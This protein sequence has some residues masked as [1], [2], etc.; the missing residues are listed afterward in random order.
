MNPHQASEKSIPIPKWAHKATNQ[1]APYPLPYDGRLPDQDS[2]ARSSMQN[3]HGFPSAASSSS[4]GAIGYFLEGDQM[5]GGVPNFA[6]TPHDEKRQHKILDD[7]SQKA[8]LL[9]LRMTAWEFRLKRVLKFLEDYEEEANSE[10][11]SHVESQDTVS[12]SVPMDP[13]QMRDVEERVSSQLRGVHKDHADK[14]LGLQQATYDLGDRLQKAL[15]RKQQDY[16]SRPGQQQQM[17]RMQGI[18]LEEE[19]HSF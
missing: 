17:Q 8:K 10:A 9:E 2:G 1:S 13:E 15:K 6:S 4:S 19:S 5:I 12:L 11:A 7:L 18:R 3:S 14:I 16:N